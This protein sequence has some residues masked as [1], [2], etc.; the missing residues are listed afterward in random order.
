MSLSLED[1]QKISGD[2]D[3]CID[4][5]RS[6]KVKSG[7]NDYYIEFPNHNEDLGEMKM[8]RVDLALNGNYLRSCVKS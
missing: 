6:T 1:K 7:G 8:K 3:E 4:V 5:G 2:N